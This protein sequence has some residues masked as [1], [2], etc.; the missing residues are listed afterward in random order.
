MG[1][2][3]AIGHVSHQIR[4]STQARPGIRSTAGKRTQSMIEGR[5]ASLTEALFA[6]EEPWQGQFLTL[7]A[8]LSTNWRWNERRP[9]QRDVAAWLKADPDLCREVTSLLDAWQRPR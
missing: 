6:L 8:N 7:V 9:E 3:L 2:L 5:V 1:L 4:Q